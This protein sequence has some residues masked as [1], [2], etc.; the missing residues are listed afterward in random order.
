[1][2]FQKVY[3]RFNQNLLRC[4]DIDFLADPQLKFRAESI[5]Q[6]FELLLQ[7]A[8]QGQRLRDG[9]TVVIAGVT[10]VGKSSLLNALSGEDNAI[11]TDI[12]GTTRDVLHEHITLDGVPLHIIDTAGLRDTQ[13]VVEQEGINRAH[14]AIAS[15]D[16][17]LVIVDAERMLL[18]PL[19]LPDNL[20]ATVVLNKIDLVEQH[21]SE[22]PILSDAARDNLLSVLPSH[23]KPGEP[24]DASAIIP[25]SVKTGQGLDKVKQHLLSLVGHD[26]QLEGAFIA[27]RRH[28]DAL[29][30]AKTASMAALARLQEAQMPELA[31]EELRQA[32]LALDSVTGRFDSEDLLGEIFG[33]FCIGK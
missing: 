27:R 14:R 24:T 1:V 33:S 6:Q 18:P 28:L 21:S 7:R 26:A 15:A 31:A 32:Q 25:V 23:S 20:S 11:V 16:H 3:C 9:L 29:E 13:D 19:N 8:Q 30:N 10:N 12:E 4:E 17:V 22:E 2:S 5:V